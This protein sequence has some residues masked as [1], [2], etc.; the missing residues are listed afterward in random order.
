[1]NL[2][3]S[4][5]RTVATYISGTET[6]A[7]DLH[8]FMGLAQRRRTGRQCTPTSTRAS[9]VPQRVVAQKWVLTSM[10]VL[11]VLGRC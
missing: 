5:N 3:V 1:V 2:V 7:A 8:H 11:V 4:E 6:A 9:T 10:F